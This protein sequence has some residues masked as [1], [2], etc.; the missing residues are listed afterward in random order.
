MISL[1]DTS[2]IFENLK[3]IK[4]KRNFKKEIMISVLETSSIVQC[5]KS[6]KFK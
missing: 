1:F 4:F 6:I 5:F 3:I 2:S